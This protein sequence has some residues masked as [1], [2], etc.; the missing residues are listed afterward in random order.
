MVSQFLPSKDL[1]SH[2]TMHPMLHSLQDE[3]LHSLQSTK[4]QGVVREIGNVELVKMMIIPI[5]NATYY[6]KLERNS[7]FQ[8]ISS[9][10]IRCYQGRVGIFYNNNCH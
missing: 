4:G 6:K 1:I 9:H 3:M 2:C 8:K 5:A 7:L 10:I